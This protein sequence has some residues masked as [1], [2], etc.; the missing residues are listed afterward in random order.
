[1]GW[2]QLLTL[3]IAAVNRGIHVI[4]FTEGINNNS[5]LVKPPLLGLINGKGRIPQGVCS[6]GAIRILLMPWKHLVML[7]LFDS[8]RLRISIAETF[9]GMLNGVI[10]SPLLNTM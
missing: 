10:N 4:L 2:L 3:G 8:A 9:A 6:L 5:G 7:M 1:M